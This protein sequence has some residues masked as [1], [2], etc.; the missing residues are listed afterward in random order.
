MNDQLR[1]SLQRLGVEAPAALMIDGT[2]TDG[3]GETLVVNSPIDGQQIAEFSAA[4]DAQAQQSIAEAA[5]A[6]EG[7]RIVPAPRRGELV[8]RFG[9]AL[10]AQKEDLAIVVSY[11][12]GKIFQESLGEVQ[13]K[14]GG[15]HV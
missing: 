3:Q 8:R 12:A 4:T 2:M 9:E 13:R 5:C 6:F 11:E 14:S 7:W 1:T 15:T 10:R